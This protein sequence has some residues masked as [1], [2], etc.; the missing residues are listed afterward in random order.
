[1]KQGD[2]QWSF[3]TDQSYPSPKPRA[4]TRWTF[5]PNCELEDKKT[6]KKESE[7]SPPTSKE[8]DSNSGVENMTGDVKRL[9]TGEKEEK[10]KKERKGVFLTSEE[11]DK[12]GETKKVVVWEEE[13][14]RGTPNL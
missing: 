9:E 8:E 14:G 2:N 3:K 5:L 13:R 11:R 12:S 4:I 6:E 7:P 10:P 1:M